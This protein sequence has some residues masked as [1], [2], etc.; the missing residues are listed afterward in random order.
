MA[1]TGLQ[2]RKD[3]QS[4]GQKGISEADQ[5]AQVFCPEAFKKINT[6]E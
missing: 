3:A 1:G 5:G 6:G 4:Q 2:K